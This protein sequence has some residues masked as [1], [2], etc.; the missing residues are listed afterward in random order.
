[1]NNAEALLEQTRQASLLSEYPLMVKDD[2]FE[3]LDEDIAER[4]R[5]YMTCKETKG[6]PLMEETLK[7]IFE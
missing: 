5:S 7:M 1:V 3:Y 2:V 6:E 4:S